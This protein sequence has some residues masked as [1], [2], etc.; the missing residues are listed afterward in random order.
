VA[1]MPRASMGQKAER[2]NRRCGARRAQRATRRA[3]VS[4]GLDVYSCTADQ[5]KAGSA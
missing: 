2:L 3:Q 4:F 1:K 5:L